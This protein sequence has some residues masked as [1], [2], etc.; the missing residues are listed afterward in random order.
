MPSVA[1]GSKTPNIDFRKSLLQT[2]PI[3]ER[4][5]QLHLSHIDDS[6]WRAAP[7]TGK[8]RSTGSIAAHL[9]Q[10]RFIWLKAADKASRYPAAQTG[11]AL[12]EWGTLWRE[13]GFG[14]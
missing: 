6:A 8:G 11:F 13:C 14:K 7:A 1:P 4:G 10:V 9:H 12:W 2:F 3:N 5:N